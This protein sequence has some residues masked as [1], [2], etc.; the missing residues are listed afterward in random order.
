MESEYAIHYLPSLGRNV[1]RQEIKIKMIPK[2]SCNL[3]PKIKEG[4]LKEI[5]AIL[6]PVKVLSVRVLF[7]ETVS[8]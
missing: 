7:N 2:L 4:K 6:L 1:F 5:P 3:P 8:Y